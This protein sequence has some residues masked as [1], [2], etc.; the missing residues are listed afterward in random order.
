MKGLAPDPEIAYNSGVPTRYTQGPA[1]A[2]SWNALA[3]GWT[4]AIRS[5]IPRE[6]RI[7]DLHCVP[8]LATDATSGAGGAA[9]AHDGP[10]PGV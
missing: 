9:G 3:V 8:S 5:P 2:N 6:V 7:D 1:P 4:Y 10:G